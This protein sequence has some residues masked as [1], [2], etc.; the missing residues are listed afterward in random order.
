MN[1]ILQKYSVFYFASRCIVNIT[2]HKYHLRYLA[3]QLTLALGP[4]LRVA[5][6]TSGKISLSHKERGLMQLC[7][8]NMVGKST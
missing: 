3:F 4:A 1:K 5:K 8:L 6:G 2:I 7:G